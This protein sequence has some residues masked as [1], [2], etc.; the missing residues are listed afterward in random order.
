MCGSRGSVLQCRFS[1][2]VSPSQTWAPNPTA[3]CEL[4]S[5]Q[6]E[7]SEV[8]V[9]TRE[10]GVE[11]RG[12]RETIRGSQQQSEQFLFSRKVAPLAAEGGDDFGTDFR[13]S[14]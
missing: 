7:V 14:V 6:N 2:T 1:L 10:K 12:M 13:N 8:P 4:V 3:A 11:A 5:Q 9:E